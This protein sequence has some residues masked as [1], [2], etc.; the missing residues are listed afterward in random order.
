MYN[1][2]QMKI[3]ILLLFSSITNGTL[4]LSRNK[5]EKKNIEGYVLEEES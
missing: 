3:E 5:R 4:F 2:T 1:N